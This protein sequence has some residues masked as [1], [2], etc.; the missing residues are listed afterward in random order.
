MLNVNPDHMCVDGTQ[1]RKVP[2]QLDPYRKQIQELIECGFQ[3]S[4]ILKKLREMYPGISI[5]RTTLSDFCVK[6]RAEL[7]DYTETASECAIDIDENSIL[8]PYTDKIGKMLAE[9]KMLTVIFTTIKAEG[10]TGSYS[11][12]QQ[13]CKKIKPATY[14][15]KKLSIK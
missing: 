6:L 2:K 1:T 15:I 5:K 4:Q 13:Y 11:M 12:L 3:T 10:Y 8:S 14:R 7:F 9:N